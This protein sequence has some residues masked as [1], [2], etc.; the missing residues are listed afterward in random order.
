MLTEEPKMWK[1]IIIFQAELL[2]PLEFSR[3]PYCVLY[4]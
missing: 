4:Y 3:E 1:L 2:S